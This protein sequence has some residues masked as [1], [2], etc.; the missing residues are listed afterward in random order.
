MI[1]WYY[2]QKQNVIKNKL[3]LDVSSKHEKELININ[4][5]SLD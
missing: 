4:L 3:Y 2:K 5:S 1:K